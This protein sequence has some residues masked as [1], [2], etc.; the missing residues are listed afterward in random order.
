ML[1]LVAAWG[2]FPLIT[3]TA[4]LAW[5]MMVVRISQVNSLVPLAF[6]LGLATIIV[7]TS[8]IAAFG[9][10]SVLGT[11]LIILGTVVG[12]TNWRNPHLWLKPM[13]PV[14]AA[15]FVPSCVAAAPV[16]LSGTATFPGYTV[17]GDTA[18]HFALVDWLSEHGARYVAQTPSSYSVTVESYLNGGYP[19]GT[20]AA[21]GALLPL[22]FQD[23]A[24]VYYPF[25]VVIVACLAVAL[26][27]LATQANLSTKYAVVAACI[28]SQPAIFVGYLLQGS[29]KEVATSYLIAL[30]VAVGSLVIS[31]AG[32]EPRPAR[33]RANCAFSAMVRRTIP[34]SVCVAAALAAIGPAVL[35]WLGPIVAAVVLL[36]LRNRAVGIRHIA[37]LSVVAAVLVAVASTG[38][39]AA[40]SGYLSVTKRVV[41]SQSEF[42]NLFG[43]LSPAQIFGIWLTGDYR[44]RPPS[45]SGVDAATVTYALIGLAAFG[46]LLGMR[47]LV[48]SPVPGG[49]GYIV[50][51]LVG[52]WYVMH[53]GSPWADAKA[54]AI[55]SPAIVF[56][57]AI[58]AVA[59]L[60]GRQ[61]FAGGLLAAALGVGIG[62]SN[63]LQYHDAS[64]APRARLQE[65]ASVGQRTRDRGPLL[66]TE[67]EEFAKHFLR[68]SDPVGAAEAFTVRGLSPVTSE[69]GRPRFGAPADL[70]RLRPSDLERFRWI[71]T[72]REPLGERPPVGWERVWTGRYYE[73]WRNAE[74]YR[75][76][77]HHVGSTP[78]LCRLARSLRRRGSAVKTLA[79][80]AR[81]ETSLFVPREGPLP[82]RW[83]PDG[84]FKFLVRTVGPGQVSGTVR[85]PA[86]GLYDVWIEGSFGRPIEVRVGGRKVGSAKY[87][88]AQPASWIRVGRARVT[89]LNPAISVT[90]GGGDLR[91]GNGDGPRTLGRVALVRSGDEP[92]LVVGARAVA[93]AACGRGVRWIELVRPRR[94]Q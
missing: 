77:E 90:R 47:R 85:V 6:P 94:P 89:S 72:R 33:A 22:S 14:I 74:S 52:T 80:A 31:L 24:W 36:A 37:V 70:E 43:P 66:Y 67:F 20:H 78:S 16:V 60:E 84:L 18:V 15:A 2:W 88:L 54:I 91:P 3:I 51:T 55:G 59:L 93:R 81:R 27:V 63:A 92:R 17:L 53:G 7:L 45:H 10:P 75:I 35:V 11:C 69:G 68:G 42:G 44:E 12:I 76:V 41:T 58:G 39:W 21:L 1:E 71:L 5:G 30:T 40:L 82:P 29:I 61:L 79:A 50:G 65:L 64:L 38:T 8:A 4:S 87:E 83:Y 49:F 28:A 9:L 25:L 62:A 23:V 34:F 48:K 46:L 19:L 26:Y 13:P 73:L 32:S 56:G 57:S 86:K